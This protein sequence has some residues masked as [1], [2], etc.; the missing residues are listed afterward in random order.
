M[1]NPSLKLHKNNF[2]DLNREVQAQDNKTTKQASKYLSV[3]DVGES[4]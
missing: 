2:S 4:K 1:A 3:H